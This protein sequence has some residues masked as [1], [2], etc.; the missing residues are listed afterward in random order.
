MM[1]RE[2]PFNQKGFNPFVDFV[3]CRFT[4]FEDGN[5]SST[6]EVRGELLNPRGMVHG[7][8]AFAMADSTMATGLMATLDEGQGCSTIEVK[9]SFLKP[10]RPGTL[11]CD[12][13]LLRRGK[14]IAFMESQVFEGDRLVATATGSFAIRALKG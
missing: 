14:R 7:G 5:C 1:P 10:M 3:G 6:L 13:Q 8:V 12:A 9:I 4:K 2:V 11:R